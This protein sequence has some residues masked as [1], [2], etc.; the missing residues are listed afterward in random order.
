MKK[1]VLIKNLLVLS[2]FLC[3]VL[4]LLGAGQSDMQQKQL[5]SM[6]TIM[7]LTAYGENAPEGLSAAEAVILSMNDMLDPE[8]ESSSTYAINHADG[9]AVP[10]SEQLAGMLS[11]ACTVYRQS[12]G[13][14]DLTLYP[15]IRRWGF[16]TSR[17][18]VP[19]DEELRADLARKAFDAMALTVSDQACAVSFPAGTEISFGATAKGCAGESAVNAMKEAGVTSG[20]VSLGGNVQTLGVKP[21]GANWKVAVQDPNNTASYVGVL[22]IGQTAVVTSG[23]YQRFFE[24]N[25]KI[26]HHL[27]DPETGRPAD[28]GLKSVTILCEDGTMADCL[29]TA[30]FVLGLDSALDYWRQYGGFEMVLITDAD[31]IICTEGLTDSFSLT[32]TDYSLR[33]TK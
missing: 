3:M 30:M 8:L 26:Y 27:L 6:D 10:I 17:Y 1:P 5:F 23:T 22:S 19:S 13:A 16:T 20:L 9:A 25:G 31:E 14:L 18:H 24:E 29:S 32:N 21:N 11:T 33:F 2:L 28:N 12:G 4:P 7:T 15:V